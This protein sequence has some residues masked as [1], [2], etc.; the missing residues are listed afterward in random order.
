MENRERQERIVRASVIGILAN[1]CIAAAKI[2]VG[3]A[4]SSL[5]I[6]SEGMNN[7]ADA[8]SSFLTLVGTKLAARHPDAKHPFGYGRIEYLTSLIVSTLILYT[9]V[10]LLVSSVQSILHPAEMEVSVMAVALV[11]GSA[12]IKYLLGTYVIREGK[13]AESQALIAVGNEG[14]NDSFFSIVTIA[15]SV[16]YMLTRISLDA[17]AGVFFAVVILK[18]GFGT[19]AE[20]ASDLI[21]RPGKKELAQKLY[22]EIRSTEGILSAADMMLHDYGPDSYSGSV[23]IEID[24]K[25]NIG[26]IYEYLHALQLRIMHEYHVTMV[27]G[28]YAVNNDG[29]ASKEMRLC[30]GR[31]IKDHEHVKSFHALYKSAE[32]GK[33]YCDLIVDYELSD[34]DCLR[35]EF[36][37]YMKQ[38]YPDNEVVLTIE[39]DFV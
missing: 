39:T 16:L 17:W 8:G 15:V 24:H 6:L 13:Q 27:F 26:D 36:L 11:A 35:R 2:L 34:W 5:A 23:N 20:T 31:F 1:L 14:R 22:Q 4:A 37:D 19:L 29:A 32:T 28:I 38:F 30:I 21:G 18:S 12:V 3:L 10:S 33:I 25:E 7:A 9:G